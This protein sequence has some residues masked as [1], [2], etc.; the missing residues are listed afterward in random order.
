MCDISR[1]LPSSEALIGQWFEIKGYRMG[2]LHLPQSV[3][4]ALG[5]ELEDGAEEHGFVWA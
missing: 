1:R 4:P 2:V 5:M 3:V